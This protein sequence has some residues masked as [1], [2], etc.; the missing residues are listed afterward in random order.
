MSLEG[1]VEAFDRLCSRF[2]CQ[3][4]SRLIGVHRIEPLAFDRLRAA[5]AIYMSKCLP[6][7]R[8]ILEEE[9]LL[10]QFE[11]QAR[12]TKN[13]TPNGM[14]V[15]KRNTVLEYNALARVFADIV[16]GLGVEDLIVSW[17]I[18]LNLRIK[19]GQVNE[20]NLKRNFPT[21]QIH[22]D[23]W[24]GE[25]SESVTTHIPIFGD[26][27]RNHLEFYEPPPTF[28]EDWLGPQAGYAAGAEVAEKYAKIDLLPER[29][30][31]YFIDFATLHAST[32]LPGAGP[33][34]SI[35]T[36]FV[37]KKPRSHDQPEKIHPW[38]EN[39]RA[40]HRVLAGLGET[41]LF[42]FPD[43][44]EQQVDVSGGFKH[45]TRLEIVK[46]LEPL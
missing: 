6:E 35:D 41:H 10:R 8:V 20:E 7:R 40:S 45:P 17:H 22:S 34:V 23:S 11:L 26:V 4:P 15:P 31:L 16:G 24:A 29:G 13:I 5:A 43:N 39:E 32:R 37:L 14:I 2:E 21:E 36:T 25:S 12:E 38:R 9:E 18:P 1:R 27:A 28:Q 33:R 46:L 19:Y 42:L 44:L 3:R 30:C